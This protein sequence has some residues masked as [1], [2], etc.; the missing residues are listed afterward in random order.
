MDIL[1]VDSPSSSV[2]II[3]VGAFKDNDLTEEA[4]SLGQAAIERIISSSHFKGRGGDVLL[5]PAPESMN[6]SHLLLVGLGDK[7]DIDE[8][9]MAKT[10]ARIVNA[11]KRCPG[12]TLDIRMGSVKANGTDH[13]LSMA[14]I[15][16]GAHLR[17]YR[18]DQYLTKE[19]AEKKPQLSEVRIVS[20]DAS[21]V[22]QAYGPLRA[23]GEGSLLARHLVNEPANV[24]N[25]PRMVEEAKALSK[26]GVKIE[27]LGER[28]M[29]SL[30]MNALLGVGRASDHESQLVIMQWNG[31]GKEDA[32]VAFV[33]KGVTFDSGGLSL[34]PAGAMEEM[35]M[36]MGGAGAVIGTM[37]ALAMRKAKVNAIGVMGLVENMVSGDA[38]RPG[39]I[40]KSMSGQTIEVLNTDAEG[41]LVL[42]DA[43]WYT[44]DRFKPQIM[45]DLATLTGAILICLGTDYAGLFSN[46][47][48]LTQN[49]LKSGK[50]V[51]E[52][53]WHLP[54]DAFYD[55]EIDSV[56]ADVRNTHKTRMGPGS[57][58]A[59]K[60]LE[61]FVNKTPWAHLDIA[62]AAYASKQQAFGDAGATGYGVRLLDRLV[63]DHYE[64]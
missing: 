30:G 7:K 56:V 63:K 54:T 3:A 37:K 18:F 10:G 62:G 41:R 16:H 50:A 34:K 28:K 48:E 46:N 36:D 51:D 8:L 9:A 20:N 40:V 11:L 38:Q 24:V 27:V 33:G 44:Q 6:A 22:E 4:K 55:K 17:S 57:I 49:L 47:D 59:A 12:K 29:Q 26:L 23:A 14:H 45:I 31:A 15:A 25:P 1:F 13:A 32:P 2:D 52:K 60:F 21:A 5:V 53:L 19:A 61:R 43:L 35:K 64:S 58:T 42:A 39:D